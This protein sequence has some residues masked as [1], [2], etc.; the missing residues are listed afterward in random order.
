MLR[1]LHLVLN[2]RDVHLLEKAI[3]DGVV[4]PV[5]IVDDVGK[6]TSCLVCQETRKKRTPRK[7]RRTHRS[8]LAMHEIATYIAVCRNTVFG[9]FLY[10]VVFIDTHTRLKA[11]YPLKRKTSK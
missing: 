10:F 2:H 7:N 5:G 1:D 9:D 3:H 6:S 11:A 8:P 4:H